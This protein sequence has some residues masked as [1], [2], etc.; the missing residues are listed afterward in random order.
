MDADLLR[1]IE[2][3]CKGQL[4]RAYAFSYRTGAFAKTL[5]E[6]ITQFDKDGKEF[7]RHQFA[8]YDE[9][10]NANGYL[11][12]GAAKMWDTGDDNVDAPMLFGGDASAIGGTS[13][14]NVGGHLYVG[15]GLG[16]KKD[17]SIGGKV[18]GSHSSSKGLL[19][20][21]DINGDGLPDKVFGA[22]HQ[23]RPNLSGPQ[24]GTRFGEAASIGLSDI[25]R[26]KSNMISAG[27]EAYAGAT[28]G[29]NVSNTFSETT[30][31]LSDVNGDGLTDL[32]SGGSVTFGRPDNP[33]AA[34]PVPL[35]SGDSSQT[36]NPVGSGAVD[37]QNLLE[38]MEELYQEMLA[39]AP[40]H[41]TLRRWTAPYA[42][43]RRHGPDRGQQRGAASLRHC[44]R[45]AGRHPA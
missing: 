14:W 36:P 25:S 34:R 5:L 27:A 26:E 16:P 8:Y 40:L 24:G 28:V 44:G 22:G 30:A 35:Y 3:R 42:H 39:A 2:V 11:G 31:Y 10:R 38:N 6:R 17:V 15:V 43:Q 29:L 45:R 37:G 13:G 7:N 18:G 1:K 4:V 33:E 9:A 32:V 19:A 41:D 12:F 21:S 20:L 23:F